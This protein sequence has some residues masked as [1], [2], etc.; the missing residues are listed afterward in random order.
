ML[1]LLMNVFLL[2][3]SGVYRQLTCPIH[4]LTMKTI[5]D[6]CRENINIMKA[7][8]VI[9][10]YGSFMFVTIELEDE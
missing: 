3:E 10:N 7:M 4:S 5:E 2:D 1:V 6:K 9:V 8:S